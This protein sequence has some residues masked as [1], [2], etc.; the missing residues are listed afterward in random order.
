MAVGFCD[1]ALARLPPKRKGHGAGGEG[2][3]LVHES[4]APWK[5]TWLLSLTGK[6][7]H[8][9]KAAP[10]VGSPRT[11]CRKDSTPRYY[12]HISVCGMIV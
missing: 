2:G 5:S 4:A 3:I 9:S 12:P 1:I 6:L 10:A 8:Y 11:A 7:V